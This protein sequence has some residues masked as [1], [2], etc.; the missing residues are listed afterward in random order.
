LGVAENVV[1]GAADICFS[2]YCVVG[3]KKKRRKRG[4][5]K[6]SSESQRGAWGQCRSLAQ[7]SR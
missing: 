5:N 1:D 4:E 3:E 7:L 6:T 2:Y